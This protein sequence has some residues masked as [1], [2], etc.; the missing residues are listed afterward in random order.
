[1]KDPHRAASLADAAAAAADSA[2]DEAGAALG[3]VVA[4]TV[5]LFYA[6]GV[7]TDEFERLALASLPL[8]EAVKDHAGLTRVWRSLSAA[9]EVRGRRE[10]AAQASE[11]ALGQARLARQP[12]TGLFGLDRALAWGPRPADEALADL[13]AALGDRPAPSVLLHRAALVAMLGRFEEAWATGRPANEALRAQ[14]GFGFEYILAQIAIW[15]DDLELA[16]RYLRRQCDDLEALGKLTMLATHSAELARCLC[17]L[18]RYA[19]AEPLA[20]F[21]RTLEFGDDVPWRQAY[22]LLNAHRGDHGE[23]EALARE[24]VAITERTDEPLNQGDTLCDLAEVLAAAGRTDEAAEALEQALDRYRRK[25]N[26]AMVAQVT[27][28]LEELRARVS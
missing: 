27:P 15:E 5:R 8:L 7:S 28:K 25:K 2:G 13:D 20:E 11:H 17:V 26:L 21:A 12:H 22:A 18:G 4:A 19:E 3:R 23:A 24:A 1:M 14:R 10:D 6:G 9:A 16:A